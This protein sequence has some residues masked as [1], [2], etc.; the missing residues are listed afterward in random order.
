MFVLH[1]GRNG[2]YRQEQRS[3]TSEQNQNQ[4]D[5]LRTLKNNKLKHL[6]AA[7]DAKLVSCIKVLIPVRP[8]VPPG[9]EPTSR[10]VNPA[11]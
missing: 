8:G 6:N 7:D 4:Q 3:R 2:N 5:V 9:S 10:Q 1:R 11:F